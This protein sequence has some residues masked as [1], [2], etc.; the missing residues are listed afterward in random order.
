MARMTKATLLDRFMEE[1]DQMPANDRAG[2]IAILETVDKLACRR[3]A[4]EIAA[5]VKRLDKSAGD[6]A[7]GA[8]D[9]P[10]AVPDE[11]AADEHY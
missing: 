6:K 4:A 11:V 5:A 8:A 1:F 9:A 2:T 3:E 7:A 10:V